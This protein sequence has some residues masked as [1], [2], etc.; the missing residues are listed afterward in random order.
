M[1]VEAH[2]HAYVCRNS[3]KI[4]S[5]VLRICSGI[6]SLCEGVVGVCACGCVG[7]NDGCGENEC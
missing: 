1:S 6:R 3:A 2:E 5:G 4:V 7:V